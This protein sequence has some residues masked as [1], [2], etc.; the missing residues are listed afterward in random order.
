[1]SRQI[2][3]YCDGACTA[4]NDKGLKDPSLRHAA[5]GIFVG[6]DH[7]WNEGT[8]IPSGEKATNQV[9]E[10]SAVHCALQKA[11]SDGNL[12]KLIIKTDSKYVCDML[13]KWIYSWIRLGWK[14][15]GDAPIQNLELIQYTYRTLVDVYA[16]LGKENV[17]FVHVRGHGKEP[18]GIDKDDE[19]W[20]DWYGNMMADKLAS[21][22]AQQK[23]ADL[24]VL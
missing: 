21:S 22:A 2:T 24:S 14:R 13:T 16:C 23:R 6:D 3:V 12:D 4:N 15:P 17:Q 9:A 10:I 20:Q 1:M 5:Y 19:R 8:C 18:K 7:P 11:L